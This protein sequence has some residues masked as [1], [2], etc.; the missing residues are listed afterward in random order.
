M[1][2]RIV[3][4]DDATAL[5]YDLAGRSELRHLSAPL[6]PTEQLSD[7]AAHLHNRDLVSDRP[8]RKFDRAPLHSARRG[9]TARHATGARNN[10]REHE[11]QQFAHRIADSLQRVVQA[12]LVDE[13]VLVC[14]PHF[15]GLLRAALPPAVS[16]LII[17]EIHKDLAHQPESAVRAH[18]ADEVAAWRL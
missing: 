13:L 11:A 14:A 15:L 3:V 9:A 4:A 5:F 7:S 2:L 18:L 10:P 1:T 8:G 17:D 12:G 6:Q 16:A